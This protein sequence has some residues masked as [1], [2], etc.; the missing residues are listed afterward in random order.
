MYLVLTLFRLQWSFNDP[1][2]ETRTAFSDMVSTKA[3]RAAFIKSL[4]TFMDTYG[5]Q[6]ADIDWEVS[7]ARTPVFRSFD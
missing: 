2:A 1:K 6:G 7:H 4:M 3:N 5:F